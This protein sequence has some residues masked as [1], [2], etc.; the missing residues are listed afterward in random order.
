MD[1]VVSEYIQYILKLV[2]IKRPEM[3]SFQISAY[4]ENEYNNAIIEINEDFKYADY[5]VDY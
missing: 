2:E 4:T 3:P 1:D 5:D